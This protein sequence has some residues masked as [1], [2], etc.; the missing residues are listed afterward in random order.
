MN[1]WLF[2]KTGTHEVYDTPLV[3]VVRSSTVHSAA[4]V[5]EKKHNGFYADDYD[6][7]LL[8]PSGKSEVVCCDI[9]EG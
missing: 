4:K 8:R 2:T 3:V 5:F 6:I 7:T 9:R 1:L